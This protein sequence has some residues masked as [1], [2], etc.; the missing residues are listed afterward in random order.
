MR[1]D[2]IIRKSIQ[3]SLP[4]TPGAHFLIVGPP[5][6]GKSSW[7]TSSLTKG[8]P[9]FRCYDSLHVIVPN[10][11]RQSYKTDPSEGHPKTHAD[12]T[13]E[14][15]A[16]ILTEIKKDAAQG[17]N[18]CLYIDDFAFS[19][20]EKAIGKLLREFMLN[21][22]HL[23]CTIMLVAQTLRSTG[24]HVRKAAS[25]VLSFQPANRLEAGCLALKFCCLDPQSAAAL[26]AQAF[27]QPHDHL[28]I[29]VDSRRVFANW[30]ERIL[31][32]SF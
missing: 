28:L 20:R 26:F 1:C 4:N 7:A 9:Y 17:R 8:G 15:L 25:H 2:D 21:A 27:R 12:L 6:S 30:D 18:S 29:Y 13:P 22:R 3:F 31:P 23:R 10:N 5:G 11:S 19:L 24:P 32:R 16:K 14:I